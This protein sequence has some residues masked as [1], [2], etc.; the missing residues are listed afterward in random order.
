[1]TG[2]AHR[3][4]SSPAL[5]AWSCWRIWKPW[6]CASTS[7]AALRRCSAW[8]VRMLPVG[9]SN[10]WVG[11]GI[12]RPWLPAD[13]VHLQSLDVAGNPFMEAS[14]ARLRALACLPQRLQGLHL[15][16]HPASTIEAGVLAACGGERLPQGFAIIAECATGA[17]GVHVAAVQAQRN[18]DRAVVDVLCAALRM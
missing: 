7:S 10:R 18:V 15:D 9:T 8:A 11:Q 14:F 12:D 5:P 2:H 3:A 17:Q 6:T 1:M 13:L 4:T 16:G